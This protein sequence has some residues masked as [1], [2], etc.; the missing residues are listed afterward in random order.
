L[1]IR[2]WRSCSKFAWVRRWHP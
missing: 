2:L 1:P